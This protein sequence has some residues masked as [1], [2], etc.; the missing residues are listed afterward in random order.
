M[1]LFH[2]PS[3][4]SACVRLR[5]N[6]RTPEAC[7]TLNSRPAALACN[8]GGSLT[9]TGNMTVADKGWAEA[10]FICE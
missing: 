9:Q 10:F 4:G 7:A 1:H 2:V 8:F 3:K 5:S 6:Q